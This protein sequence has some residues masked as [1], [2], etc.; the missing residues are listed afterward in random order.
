MDDIILR[1]CEALQ[2]VYAMKKNFILENTL[3]ESSSKILIGHFSD[4]HSDIK[5]FN[6]AIKLFEYLDVAFAVHTGDTVEWNTD[7]NYK[8]FNE[9]NK[10]TK[11]PLYNC[12]GNHE[13]FNNSGNNTNEFL[14]NELISPLENI[15]CEN[16]RGYYYVD[17]SEHKLRLIVLNVYDYDAADAGSNREI[18]TLL[19]EQCE[20]LVRTLKESSKLGYGVM[21]ASHDVDVRI[22]PADNE[23]GFC[24]R[25]EA[26]PWG[27][28]KRVSSHPIADIIDAF[29]HAKEINLDFTW[30]YT[31]QNVK[32]SDRFDAEGEFICY[33]CGHR[34]GDYVGYLKPY[35]DQLSICMTC[36]GCFPEGY[37]NIG[38]ELSDLPRIPE[39]LTEDAVN[40][41]TLDRKEKT[42]TIVRVGACINDELKER[43]VLK[44]KYS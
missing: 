28:H 23:F 12:I 8:F 36:S 41:Y 32:I 26:F 4:M 5:R 27:A 43:R 2:Y 30:D 1:N 22:P 40:I 7:S 9:E 17:F 19:Q 21:I 15:V 13:T 10:Q 33:L 38:E 39:T 14:H 24:Q 25:F 37:H 6:N 16:K 31:E 34:H 3:S 29:K 20:W 44:L 18:F 42:M 35:P 11:I